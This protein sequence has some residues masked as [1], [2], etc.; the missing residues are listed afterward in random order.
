MNF[1]ELL[2]FLI[3]EFCVRETWFPTLLMKADAFVDEVF[4]L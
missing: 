2:S 1:D 3:K 4:P